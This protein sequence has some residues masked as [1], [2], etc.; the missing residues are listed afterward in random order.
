[1]SVTTP[2][3]RFPFQRTPVAG[4]SGLILLDGGTDVLLGLTAGDVVDANGTP[5]IIDG[6]QL[7][8]GGQVQVVEQD[9]AEHIVSCEQVIVSCPTGARWARPEFGWPWPIFKGIPLDT[10]ALQQALRTFEP[11]SEA[12]ATDLDN[13]ADAALRNWLVQIPV[14]E[15]GNG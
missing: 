15:D 3:L 10:G 1:V 8:T 12:T 2:H 13:L 7:S 11:R 5:P 4:V 9:T 14:Q 6:N